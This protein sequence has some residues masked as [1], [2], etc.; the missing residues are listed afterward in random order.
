MRL[1]DSLDL[2]LAPRMILLANSF[3]RPRSSSSTRLKSSSEASRPADRTRRS[4]FPGPR[5]G[6]FEF[7]SSIKNEEE[8]R[9]LRMDPKGNTP[10]PDKHRRSV[11]LDTETLHSRTKPVG[12]RNAIRGSRHVVLTAP[13]KPAKLPIKTRFHGMEGADTLRDEKTLH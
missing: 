12:R 8:P 3:T 11:T 1:P 13:P 10:H 4:Q 2:N 5:A 7:A 6:S 9:Y